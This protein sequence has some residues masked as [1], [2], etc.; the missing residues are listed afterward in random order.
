VFFQLIDLG[1]GPGAGAQ[2]TRDEV[3]RYYRS[4]A[5]LLELYL[6]VRR[7]DRFV[8]QPLLHRSDF[9]LPGPVAR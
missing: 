2:L 1:E 4:D 5:R 7:M 8:K 6:R 9:V 3:D